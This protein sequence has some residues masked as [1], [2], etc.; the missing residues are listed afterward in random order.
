M[1]SLAI[2]VEFNSR[3]TQPIITAV[4]QRRSYIFMSEAIIKISVGLVP[5]YQ[6]S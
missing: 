4:I 6:L 1:Y 5:P 2:S 3:R